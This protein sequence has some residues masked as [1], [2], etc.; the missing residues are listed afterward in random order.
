M[1]S[2]EDDKQEEN[3]AAEE[4]IAEG[5]AYAEKQEETAEEEKTVTADM[6]DAGADE[7]FVS[8]EDVSDEGVSEDE[9]IFEYGG[10]SDDDR[11]NTQTVTEETDAGPEIMTGAE[12]AAQEHDE[13]DE[14]MSEEV[15]EEDFSADTQE[16][17]REDGEDNEVKSEQPDKKDIKKKKGLSGIMKKKMSIKVKLIGAFMIPVILIIILGVISYVTAS[18]AIKSSFIEASTSTI[19]K[20][21]DYYTLMFSNVSALAT[22][23]A[24]NSDVKSYY[25]GSLSN[26]VMTES[27]T[28]SNISSSLSSTAMGNKA[29]KAAYVIGSYGRSIFTSTTSMETT[30][31]YSNIKAS[32]EGQ[33][34]D[35]D[36]TAWFTSREYLDTRG[37]GDYAVSYGRQLVGNSGKSVGYIFFDLNSDYV[38]D[39]LTDI[40]LGKNS[41]IAL[42]APDGG[43]IISSDYLES[44]KSTRYISDKDFYSEAVSSDEKSGSSFVKYNGKEQLFVYSIT[45]DGFM[46][47]ALIPQSTIIAQA[48]TIKYVSVVL[49][50]A[51][52]VVAVFIGGILASNISRAIKHIMQRLEKAAAGDLTISVD[53]RRSDEFA[54]LG[55]S[56]NGMINNVK[57]LIEKTKA[58]SDKVDVSVETVTES[59]RELLAE[60]QKITMAIQEI[61]HGVIQQAEDSED[62]LRQMDNLSE[63]INI[64]SENSGKIARIAEETSQIVESGMTSIHEL[65]NNADDTVN[66]THQVISEINKLKASS[67]SIGN[68]IGAI[69]EIAEQTNLL[70]L[71]ASIE[72]ARAGEAGRG[73]AVV[74]DEI[75]KLADQSVNSVNEIRKIVED[76]NKKTND[77]VD[78]AKRAEDVVEIQGKSLENAEQVFDHIQSQFGELISNL[79]E[80]TSGIGTIADSKAQTI[81]AI[82][83]ISAVS[84]QTAAASEEVTETA[85]RQLEQV[86]GLNSAAQDLSNNS[87][88]LAK[89]IDLFKI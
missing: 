66:I 41:V 43:E 52:I 84:Q 35:Q 25:S 44:D 30:G 32:A 22:D 60:T 67:Q 45:D 10:A 28:Y 36:R 68:I 9:D 54:V 71:N 1:S 14:E 34:I 53:L 38:A 6:S 61:E 83:S 62:C 13:I 24:N 50:I 20:T 15:P 33:K 56:T 77:T 39:T 69:N 57:K 21:A 65:K 79:D 80:I 74:A 49:I 5:E 8:G 82:E 86:E 26:D 29:I 76:I 42:I 81:D 2:L 78:I 89:A 27:T 75:R 11:A 48:N 19:Q 85:N 3:I 23:F 73:F 64:V 63:K 37:V 40:D 7:D 55:S 51:T 17:E 18:N 46:V 12:E 88:A 59:A 58:V 70:S 87:E 16:E 31:E 47:C 4:I 72:A